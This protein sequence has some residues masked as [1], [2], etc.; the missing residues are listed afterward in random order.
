MKIKGIEISEETIVSALTKA[1]IN[2]EPPKF[3]PIKFDRLTVGT[4]HGVNC[5]ITLR[6]G[7][8]EVVYSTAEVRKIIVALQSAINFAERSRK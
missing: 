5:P 8:S 4:N 7:V 3:K 2:L 6:S 1:G